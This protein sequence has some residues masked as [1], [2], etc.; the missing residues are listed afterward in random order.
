MKV[1]SLLPLLDEIPSPDPDERGDCVNEVVSCNK[2][3]GIE[4]EL[5]SFGFVKGSGT[6]DTI[7]YS[8][9]AEWFLILSFLMI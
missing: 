6:P 2:S 8:D 7:R 9:T 5:T 3:W 1:P 4:F